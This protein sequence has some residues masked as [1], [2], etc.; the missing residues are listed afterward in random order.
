[1]IETRSDLVRET[2]LAI[3]DD[4]GAIET[5]ETWL[6][7]NRDRLAY[8]SHQGGCG[9][10]VVDWNIEGPREVVETLPNEL[11]CSSEWTR[12]PNALPKRHLLRRWFKGG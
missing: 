8:V 4:P 11:R 7:E 9:C 1:V 10:C 5:A 6:R 3:V 12:D 2:I